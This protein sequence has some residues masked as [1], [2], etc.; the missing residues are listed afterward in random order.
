MTAMSDESQHSPSEDSEAEQDDDLSEEFKAD[1][2]IKV[3]G[4]RCVQDL[5]KWFDKKAGEKMKL[6]VMGWNGKIVDVKERL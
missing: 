6:E 1:G 5:I 2:R 4:R 3:K